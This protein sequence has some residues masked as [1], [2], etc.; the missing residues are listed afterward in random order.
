VK[1][2]LFAA[3]LGVL[4]I[5]QLRPD[6]V[7]PAVASGLLETNTLF[8]VYGRG[9]GRAPILGHLGTY[10]DID[11]MAA[12]TRSWVTNI[13]AANGGKGVVI[14]IHLIYG[15]AI[16]CT[17]AGNCVEYLD[18]V[19]REL[20][21]RYIK[22]AAER[23]WT[24]ILDTQLGR[25]DPVTEVKR[26]MDRGYLKYD[27][28]H[29]A[30]DPEFHSVPGHDDPGIPI[31]TVTA[32]QINEVQEMLSRYV[33]A[34]GLKTKKILIVHQFGDAAVHDGVPFMI[35]DKGDLKNFANVELVVDADGLGTPAEKI[36][37]YNLMTDSRI[38]P[39][40]RFG[41]LKVFFPNQWEHAGHFDK[42]PMT[43]DQ[44]FG[45]APVPGGLRMAT[46]PSVLI[47]A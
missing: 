11:A 2:T 14:G 31:G 16:P 13:G 1:T 36:R 46:R 9:F 26:M 35:E 24:V 3:L 43:T 22:P 27:N 38:Y 41:A 10:E 6:S 17:A 40:V 44:V 32:A 19:D 42:P 30:I 18:Q 5:S 39:A 33:E 34:E 45:M 23:G 29:V 25:S 47:I 28:V 21:E 37:K 7:H 20:V 4:A 12:D 8:T 15:L